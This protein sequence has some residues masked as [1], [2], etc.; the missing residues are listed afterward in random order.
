MTEGE[1]VNI[2]FQFMGP[3][4]KTAHRKLTRMREE[5]IKT[6]FIFLGTKAK[7]I[8]GNL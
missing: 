2:T 7:L 6:G 1:K 8:K 4:M 3:E 5:N